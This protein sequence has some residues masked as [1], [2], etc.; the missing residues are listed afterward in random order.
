M[1]IL[2]KGL[3]LSLIFSVILFVSCSNESVFSEF[4][5]PD[6]EV[7]SNYTGQKLISVLEANKGSESFYSVLTENQKGKILSSLDSIISSC[8]TIADRN[9]SVIIARAAMCAVDILLHTDELSYAMIYD[10]TNP[11]LV[12]LTGKGVNAS[13]I[14]YAYTQPFRNCINQGTDCVLDLIAKSFY[15]LYQITE[16]YDKAIQ[17]SEYADYSGSDIQK[18]LIAG[19]ISSILSGTANAMDISTNKIQNLSDDIAQAYINVVQASVYELQN[20]LNDVFNQIKSEIGGTA[21]D[22]ETAYK[23]ELLQR[24]KMLEKLSMFA[25]FETIAGTASSILRKWGND[26]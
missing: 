3:L 19:L 8:E 21:S 2:Q 17:S 24:A 16:Y 13:T 1:K 10:I 20:I 7:I 15:N 14:F 23:S 11:I 6:T 18:Y 9:N 26:E 22:I 4:D 5:K 12:A 25:G